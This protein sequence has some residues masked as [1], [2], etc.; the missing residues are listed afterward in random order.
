[1]AR[2]RRQLNYCK[3]GDTNELVGTHIVVTEK[4]I[5]REA[6]QNAFD[7]INQSK[8]RLRLV[9]DTI[10]TLVWRAGPDGVPDFLN[11]TALDYTGLSPDHAQTDWPRE[12]CIA[13]ARAGEP[14]GEAAEWTH[15]LAR[16]KRAQVP[17][18]K[19]V[20]YPSTTRTHPIATGAAGFPREASSRGPLGERPAEQAVIDRIVRLRRAGRSQRAIASALRADGVLVSR[21]AIQ[22][23]LA[24]R[25]IRRRSKVGRQS[26][27]ALVRAKKLR[28]VFLEFDGLTAWSAAKEMNRRKIRTPAG[29]RWHANSIERVRARLAS[30]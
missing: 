12:P 26:A 20:L 17:V 27:A 25:D 8:D 30:M 3:I 6:V 28:R 11:Q 1:V 4:H 29:G 18:A 7:E 15:L 23:L 19:A 16:M 10:P 9:I 22:R 21:S 5:A 14:A 13:R 2:A 24:R